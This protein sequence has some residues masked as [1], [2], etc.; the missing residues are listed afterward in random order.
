MNVEVIVNGR[1][2]KVAIEPGA[3]PGTFTVTIKGNSRQVDASWIDA[4]TV[5]LIDGGVAREIRLHSHGDN[6]AVAV[7]IGGT[8]YEA[9]VSRRKRER[10]TVAPVVDGVRHVIKAPM[11]GR[12]MDR[13]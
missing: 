5:S 8:L 1:N 12:V 6:R 4:E 13:C 10:E 2:L 7:E 3:Q 11:P 9:L